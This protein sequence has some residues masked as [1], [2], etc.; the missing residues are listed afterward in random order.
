M[1]ASFKHS[2][3][4]IPTIFRLPIFIKRFINDDPPQRQLQCG[5]FYCFFHKGK[6]WTKVYFNEEDCPVVT[7]LVILPE[8]DEDKTCGK[9]IFSVFINTVLSLKPII[10]MYN[11]PDAVQ[12][13]NHMFCKDVLELGEFKTI[14]YMK[15]H[16]RS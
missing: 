1:I 6:S 16:G 5:R 4:N 8:T 15:K 13:T 12:Y 2:W 3:D 7:N 14:Y 9:E 10:I 11:S